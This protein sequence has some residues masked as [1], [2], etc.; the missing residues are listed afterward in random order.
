MPDCYHLVIKGPESATKAFIEGLVVGADAYGAVYFIDDLNVES[1][2]LLEWIK[3]LIGQKA[4]SVSILA[5]EPLL[6]VITK[7]I[8]DQAQDLDI[9]LV[10]TRKVIEAMF[11]FQ[12]VCFST[13]HAETIR[14]LLE[15]PP[16]QVFASE[17][18][19][20]ET[21]HDPSAEGVELYSPAHHFEYRGEG[22]LHGKT[23]KVIEIYQ[24]AKNEPLIKLSK[25]R[26]DF[27]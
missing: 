23:R 10:A 26:F 14:A 22:I 6:A 5:D 18:N 17:K 9:A 12:F 27:E 20:F 11:E 7:G 8:D 13:E 25:L 4:E 3:G 15:T 2:D 24:K 19:K 1:A 16:D 21:K